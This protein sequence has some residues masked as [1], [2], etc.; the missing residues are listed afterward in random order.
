MAVRDNGKEAITHYRILRRYRAHTHLSVQLETGR[1]HQIRVHLAHIHYPLLGDPLYG[2]RLRLPPDCSAAFAA[3]LRGFKR[4]ALHAA[5][6][7][8]VHPL[9]DEAM[10][11]EA[12]L[13][14]DFAAVLEQ[15]DQDVT[16]HG[17]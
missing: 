7:G 6:L 13:P 16:E 4:Q 8:I 17:G 2:G 5:R 11:W 1:T 14:A 12:P 9:S 10:E 15:L 3:T